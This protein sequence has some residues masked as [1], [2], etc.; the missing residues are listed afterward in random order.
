[1]IGVTG[2]SGFIGEAVMDRLGERGVPLDLRRLDAA[3]LSKV[4]EDLHAVI[5]LAGPL[6]GSAPDEVIEEATVHLARQVVAAAEAHPHLALVL[7]STIRVHAPQED[8]IDVHVEPRPFDGYGRG[9]AR[10][11][12]CFAAAG[13]ADRHVAIVRLSSVQGIDLNKQARGLVGTF[14]RQAASGCLRVMGDGLAVKDLVHVNVV[15]SHLVRLADA[16]EHGVHLHVLG[17]VRCTVLEV[18]NAVRKRTGASVE[19]G[20][21]AEGELSACFSVAV[22]DEEALMA[23][24]DEALSTV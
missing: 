13:G 11:E 24:V 19:H 14:A 15:A 10:A 17:G 2:A 22:H 7:A 4:M 23:F 3:G 16:R 21:P 8:P 18:A 20:A 6:P 5:H 9:K 12:G 1:M